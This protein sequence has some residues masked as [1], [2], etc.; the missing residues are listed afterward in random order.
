MLMFP[1][2][3]LVSLS[4]SSTAGSNISPILSLHGKYA[5]DVCVI[6]CSLALAKDLLVM[7]QVT[8]DTRLIRK[9][10]SPHPHLSLFL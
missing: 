9:R 7:G 5:I 2:K 1:S 3:A 10:R 8:L 6:I 4:P